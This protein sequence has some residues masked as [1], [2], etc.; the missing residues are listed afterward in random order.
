MAMTREQKLAKNKDYY[1]NNKEYIQ[2]RRKAYAIANPE[3][4]KAATAAA[5]QRRKERLEKDPE[6]KTKTKEYLADWYTNNAEKV[7]KNYK[8][9]AENNKEKI[10][11][12]HRKYNTKVSEARKAGKQINKTVKGNKVK[13][14]PKA[15][16][17][18]K[19]VKIVSEPEIVKINQADYL[20]DENKLISR[21]TI[22]KEL[23]I[24][25]VTL[26]RMSRTPHYNMPKHVC[27]KDNLSY[28][29]NRKE[30]EA[31]YPFALETLAFY[32]QG[33][34]L[35]RAKKGYVFKEGSM[36]WGLIMF[37]RNNKDLVLK[38]RG[39]RRLKGVMKDGRF[40]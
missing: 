8:R 31:W 5:Y 10:L 28:L 21:K 6:L 17:T 25:M 33:E 1:F 40:I 7:A 39:E 19:P 20:L 9:Y 4:T 29:Y 24:S 38:H 37:M 11:E 26:D 3:K 34:R 35:P 13:T 2:N 16:K 30:V 32:K 36:G 22:A 18:V 12:S 27:L 14:E 23:K 15:I